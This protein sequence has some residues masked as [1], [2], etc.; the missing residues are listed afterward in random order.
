MSQAGKAEQSIEDG[1]EESQPFGCLFDAPE[2]P[3][4]AADSAGGSLPSTP[5]SAAH[6]MAIEGCLAAFFSPE[7]VMWECPGES[8]KVLSEDQGLG[9][10]ANM[11]RSVSFSGKP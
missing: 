8:R 1:A 7:E 3:V 4:I 11:P 2:E 5:S 10:S 9:L 6:G